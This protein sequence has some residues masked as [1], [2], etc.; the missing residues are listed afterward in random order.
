[1]RLTSLLQTVGCACLLQATG[2]TATPAPFTSIHG[3]SILPNVSLANLIPLLDLTA[4]LANWG[5]G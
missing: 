1:M 4:I 2:C 3:L 5:V